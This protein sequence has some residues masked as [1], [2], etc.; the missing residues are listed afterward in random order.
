[1]HLTVIRVGVGEVFFHVL[2]QEMAAVASGVDQHVGSRCGH[3]AIQY[4]FQCL[5]PWLAVFK[6][7]VVAVD[8]EFFCAGCDDFDDVRQIN[9]VIFVHLDQTQSTWR[10]GVQACLDER[11]LTRATC[12]R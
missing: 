1:M 3:C 2:G 8:D 10:V 11:R 6:T 7:Q 4:R 12:T 5:V 9:Q